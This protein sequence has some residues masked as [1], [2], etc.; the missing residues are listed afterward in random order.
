MQTLLPAASVLGFK[1][2]VSSA[3]GGGWLSVELGSQRGLRVFVCA[4]LWEREVWQEWD[5]KCTKALKCPSLL[6]NL[7]LPNMEFVLPFLLLFFVFF[8]ALLLF[9]L[10][11]A[12]GPERSWALPAV[13][14]E[15]F[16]FPPWWEHFT[17]TALLHYLVVWKL[18]LSPRGCGITTRFFCLKWGSSAYLMCSLSSF[19]W[20]SCPADWQHKVSGLLSTAVEV[21]STAERAAK[22][23]LRLSWVGR[24]ECLGA[25]G[26]TSVGEYWKKAEGWIRCVW[27]VSRHEALGLTDRDRRADVTINQVRVLTISTSVFWGTLMEPRT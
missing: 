17:S 3:A 9:L 27:G 13:L 21:W 5:G 23:D 14:L 7:L 16:W 25:C 26:K 11:R 24:T 20:Q 22:G 2:N 1:V 6:R 8:I 10:L 19:V 4:F 18:F 15:Q 12:V